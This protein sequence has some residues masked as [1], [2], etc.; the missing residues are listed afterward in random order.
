MKAMFHDANINCETKLFISTHTLIPPTLAQQIQQLAEIESNVI[1][2]SQNAVN[3][4]NNV[5]N[6]T[7]PS[8]NFFCL[9]G[10]T[11]NAIEQ[12][13]STKNIK[14][15]AI[16]AV[17]LFE[18]ISLSKQEKFIFFCGNKRLDYLPSMFIKNNLLLNEYV[19]YNTE[20]TPHKLNKQYD[21]IVF[22]SPSGV[23]S[24]LLN[25]IIAENTILFS[26]GKTTASYLRKHCNNK[27]IISNNPNKESLVQLVIEYYSSNTLNETKSK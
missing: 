1:F 19:V 11:K 15:F 16:D 3:A 26:I 9:S 5:L 17:Q 2:T 22:Y 20:L 4:V 23:E 8:W 27:I 12:Y 13:W 25:N 14:A 10:S 7:T 6:E 24:F 18:K 21:A